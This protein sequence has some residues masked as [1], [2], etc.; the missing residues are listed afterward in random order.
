MSFA[1][2][3]LKCDDGAE[4]QV[5]NEINTIEEVKE[6]KET[7]GPFGAIVKIESNNENK[8]KQ[9]LNEKIRYISGIH[10]SMTLVASHDDNNDESK[11]AWE[12]IR[13]LSWIFY[14]E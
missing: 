10:S 8:V 13:G 5:L 6:A 4:K 12:E 2:V 14:E 11:S 3:L 9:I 7:S 1:Y